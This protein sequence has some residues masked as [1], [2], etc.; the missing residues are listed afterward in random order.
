MQSTASDLLRNSIVPGVLLLLSHGGNRTTDPCRTLGKQVVTTVR[1]QTSKAS[2][3]DQC[4]K[5][6]RAS[7]R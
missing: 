4:S 5:R 1:K 6:A 2:R 3:S 7:S